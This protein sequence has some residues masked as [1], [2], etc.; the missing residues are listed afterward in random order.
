MAFGAVEEAFQDHW[1]HVAG[2]TLPDWR[3]RRDLAGSGPGLWL[4]GRAGDEMVGA[5][6]CDTPAGEETG[7]IEWLAVKRPW[8]RRGM[9]LALLHAA[10][11]QIHAHGGRRAGLVVDSESP[12]G[13]GRLYGRAG[14]RV[15]RH[16]A[17]HRKRIRREGLAGD[18][19][20]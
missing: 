8:R 3:R 16:Y 13:A 12:T 18:R 9:G 4:G 15:V 11:S 14:M 20:A 2:R 5:V 6:F 7:E 17:V 19:R 1:G 10:F